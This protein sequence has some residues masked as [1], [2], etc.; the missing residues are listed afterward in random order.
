MRSPFSE[1]ADLRQIPNQANNSSAIVAAATK[2]M[3]DTTNS[4]SPIVD[5]LESE[6]ATDNLIAKTLY[7]AMT[8]SSKYI[9][10]KDQEPIET[11]D[12]TARIKAAEIASNLK[13][14]TRSEKT[15]NTLNL[16]MFYEI[17]NK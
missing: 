7:E 3:T 4:K 8:Q 14:Y 11:P 15:Q 1:Q 9:T 6:W 16:W 13:G 10:Q 17:V 2:F 5:A 12:W